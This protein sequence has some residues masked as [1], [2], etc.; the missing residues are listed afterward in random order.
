MK[1]I[2]VVDDHPV[3]REGI[4][5]LINNEKGLKVCGE[6]GDFNETMNYLSQNKPDLVLLDL[7][8]NNVDGFGLIEDIKSSYPEL[9]ILVLSAYQEDLYAERAIRCGASGYIMK[10]EKKETIV[11][12]ILNTMNNDI[13]ISEKMKPLLIRKIIGKGMKSKGSQVEDLTRR[14]F[15]VFKLIGKGFRLTEIAKS[16]GISDKT[17]RVHKENIKKKLGTKHSEKLQ[18]LAFQWVN[19]HDKI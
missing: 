10:K 13:F 18:H 12:A 8:L 17:V 1:R 19:E 5:A 16:L 4:I 15:E 14:E 9:P 7:S 6:A 2:L 11:N 3:F